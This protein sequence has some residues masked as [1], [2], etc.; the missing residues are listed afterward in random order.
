FIGQV[1]MVI[2][3]T[4]HAPASNSTQDI[5]ASERQNLFHYG[6]FADPIV[7][8]DYP[9]MMRQRIDERSA[10]QN[11]T[12][13][14]L[15]TFTDE[16][17][18]ELKGRRDDDPI[19]E[20]SM[21]DDVSV[22]TYQPDDWEKTVTY[23]FKVVPWGAR[24]LVVWI[25]NRYGDDKGI[26]VTENGYHDNGNNLTDL[27]SRGRY[28]KLYLSNLNDAIYKDAVYLIGYMAW[29]LMNDVEWYAGW[30]VNLG[31]YHVDFDSGNRTR[32][33]KE[34]AVY[35]R[36]VVTTNCLMENCTASPIKYNFN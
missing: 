29:S 31:H 34:S 30:L 2:D 18:A 22:T 21:S 19:G 5:E 4:Y 13:S 10:L 6:W 8:G 14:R 27:D 16:E 36:K 20:P 32:T 28:H 26:L 33:P 23:W 24:D 9:D 17:K 12:E 25:K 11:L 7:F 1:S 15:P 35:Y 3:T